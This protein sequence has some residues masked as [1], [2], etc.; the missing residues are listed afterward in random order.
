[1]TLSISV[2]RVK[3]TRRKLDEI[4]AKVGPIEFT[5]VDP[6]DKYNIKD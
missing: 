2:W 1:M 6:N 3:R 5:R 4:A